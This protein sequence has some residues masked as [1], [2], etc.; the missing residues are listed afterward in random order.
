MADCPTAAAIHELLASPADSAQLQ[1]LGAFGSVDELRVSL[2]EIGIDLESCDPEQTLRVIRQVLG[3]LSDDDLFQAQGGEVKFTV[4]A[5]AAGTA[6]A[7]AGGI[8][9]AGVAAGGAILSTQL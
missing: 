8:A 5:V 6:A 1:A 4:A 2:K 9:V 7:V 3:N